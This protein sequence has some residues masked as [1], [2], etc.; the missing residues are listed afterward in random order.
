[1]STLTLQC[2][3]SDMVL[4]LQLKEEMEYLHTK[5]SRIDDHLSEIVRMFSPSSTPCSHSST[6][7]NSKTTSP[8][9]TAIH[10]SDQ[11]S[12]ESSQ[13]LMSDMVPVTNE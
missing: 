3:M 11:S 6:Y 4:Q 10:S 1:M 12:A 2:L 13:C 7:P 9:N 5:I 8:K